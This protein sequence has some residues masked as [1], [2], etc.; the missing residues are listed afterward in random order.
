[1][2][3][4]E[5][6]YKVWDRFRQQDL[7]PFAKVLTPELSQ[8]A[9]EAAGLQIAR[10]PLNLGNLAW[11]GVMSALHITKAFAGVLCLTLKLLQDT[12]GWGETT[13][14]QACRPS[15]RK[16]NK[17]DPHGSQPGVVTEEAFVQARQRM[18]WG[19]WVWLVLLLSARFQEEYPDHV[20]WHGFRL[21]AM[22]GTHVPLQHWKA[23]REYFGT[24]RNGRK[25]RAPQARLVMLAFPQ[26]RLPWR[27]ELTPWACHEQ[28]IAAR[29]LQHLTA[30][31]LVLLDRGFWS[32]GLFCRIQ[33]R[34]AFFCIRLRRGVSLKHPRKLGPG[35]QVFAWRPKKRSKKKCAWADWPDLLPSIPL[36]VI[37]YQIRGFRPSAVVTNILA[38]Q[39]VP[40]E[41]FVRMAT[42]DEAGRVLEP[43]L[44]HRRWE[45]ETMFRELKVTQGMVKSLRSR[46][47]ESIRFEI[48]GHILLYFLIR[49]L[50]VEAAEQHD[51]DPLRISF[52]H[53]L[54][55]LNDMRHAL[56]TSTPQRIAKTLLPRLLQRIAD[57]LV[58]LRPG[59]HYPRPSDRYGT[60][61]Y[62]QRSKRL[63]KKT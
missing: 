31:D 38:P 29:L 37:R 61:K 46:T 60:G 19:Y 14:G 52:I 13:L 23:L 43:A 42:E 30:D 10:S 2:F 22:D 5:R 11:L 6:R 25:R 33:S 53:A 39:R 63:A 21:L 24:A 18:P 40:A 4:D 12:P 34:K 9:A 15:R 45:I 56:L 35:D 17:H 44:Y 51:L 28:T 36:R 41:D 49:R 26:A 55:E 7:R 57:H 48:A 16:R 1:M 27:Y 20:Y 59:R 58:P 50:M 32:F 47:P 62:R 54:R 8:A 3:T